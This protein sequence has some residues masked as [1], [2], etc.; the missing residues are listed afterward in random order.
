MIKAEII[1]LYNRKA[2][3]S[4]IGD[5]KIMMVF[6]IKTSVSVNNIQ[7]TSSAVLLA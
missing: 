5:D 7:A 4:W 6:L 3:R 2:R 1:I